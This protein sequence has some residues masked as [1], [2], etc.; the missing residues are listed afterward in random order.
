MEL[1]NFVFWVLFLH[2]RPTNISISNMLTSL[3]CVCFSDPVIDWEAY[4][5]LWWTQSF[6]ISRSEEYGFRVAGAWST[7]I[8]WGRSSWLEQGHLWVLSPILKMVPPKKKKNGPQ[9]YICLPNT[10]SEAYTFYYRLTRNSNLGFSNS[11][12][13]P[14][15]LLEHRAER[16]PMLVWSLSTCVSGARELL[17]QELWHTHVNEK[18]GQKGRS[19]ICAV[20]KLKYDLYLKRVIKQ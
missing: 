10:F 20:T 12:P 3:I 9:T 6:S 14:E 2:A 18:E 15:I 7:G 17:F 4:S 19:Y 8:V 1:H 5:S 16:N 11:V 13:I